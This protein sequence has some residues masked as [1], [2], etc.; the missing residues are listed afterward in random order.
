MADRRPRD[1]GPILHKVHPKSRK[2]AQAT[3]ESKRRVAKCRKEFRFAKSKKPIVSLVSKFQEFVKSRPGAT[4]TAEDVRRFTESYLDEKASVLEELRR[5]VKPGHV[6]TSSK[7]NKMYTLQ[8]TL[9]E[10][11]QQFKLHGLEVPDLTNP[12]C[13]TALLEWKGDY[14]HIS[15]KLIP[16]KQFKPLNPAF[17]VT[18]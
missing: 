11:R 5:S 13:V 1:Q 3:R 17:K 18:L 6:V 9:E 15:Q 2:A 4:F 8:T 16:F 14:E 10:E 7:H 12:E